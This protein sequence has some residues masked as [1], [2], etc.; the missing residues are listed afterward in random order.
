MDRRDI[1]PPTSEAGSLGSSTILYNSSS[2]CS[3]C[4]VLAICSFSMK[5]LSSLISKHFSSQFRGNRGGAY[6][7]IFGW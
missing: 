5:K 6:G 4:A 7:G 1:V 2:N 3:S